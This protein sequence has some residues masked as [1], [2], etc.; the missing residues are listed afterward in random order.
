MLYIAAAAQS[1]IGM[2]GYEDRSERLAKEFF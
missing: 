2:R 1:A